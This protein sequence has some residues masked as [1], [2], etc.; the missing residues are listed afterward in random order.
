MLSLLWTHGKVRFDL[1]KSTTCFL[2]VSVLLACVEVR[3][4][5]RQ[6]LRGHSKDAQVLSRREGQAAAEEV[7]RAISSGNTI[8]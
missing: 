6:T 5:R 2:I 4:F 8:H 3:V 1:V 7:R